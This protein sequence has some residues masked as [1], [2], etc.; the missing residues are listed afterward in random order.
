LA[1]GTFVGVDDT[2]FGGDGDYLFGETTRILGG[3]CAGV[4]AQRKGVGISAGDAVKLRD[5]LGGL[6]HRQRQLRRLG[7]R[8]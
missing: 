2:L 6:T 3:Y 5:L 8:P 4:A 7:S 1:P